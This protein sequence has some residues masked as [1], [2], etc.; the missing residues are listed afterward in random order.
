MEARF[1]GPLSFL[2]ELFDSL[3]GEIMAAGPAGI[4]RDKTGVFGV[5]G[6]GNDGPTERTRSVVRGVIPVCVIPKQKE[7]FN[8]EIQLD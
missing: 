7:F 4:G 3:R 1:S 8:Q 2:Y 5:F 6:Q